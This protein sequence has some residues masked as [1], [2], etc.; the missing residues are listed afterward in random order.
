MELNAKEKQLLQDFVR[1]GY[2]ERYS[3]KLIG[4]GF[5]LFSDEKCKWYE[6]YFELTGTD[7]PEQEVDAYFDVF[8]Y[9]THL[10]SNHFG[11]IENA[12][13]I[14]EILKSKNKLN[15]HI[16]D[17]VISFHIRR[18]GL[19]CDAGMV[20]Y[21]RNEIQ[22]AVF[23]ASEIYGK[24]H[25]KTIKSLAY[26]AKMLD[27]CGCTADAIGFMRDCYDKS[28]DMTYLEN[29]FD[30]SEKLPDFYYDLSIDLLSELLSLCEKNGDRSRFFYFVSRRSVYNYKHKRIE[31]SIDDAKNVKEY[32]YN[33]HIDDEK[34][35]S[36][37]NVS[38]VYY[39][40]DMHEEAEPILRFLFEETYSKMKN[41]EDGEVY[42][43]DDSDFFEI[44]S[45]LFDSMGR[46]GNIKESLDECSKI[47]EMCK[48]S[49]GPYDEKTV[50][51]ACNHARNIY[52]SGK[53]NYAVKILTNLY[54][55]RKI[56][57]EVVR[58]RILEEMSR[59]CA[60]QNRIFDT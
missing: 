49:L 50:I 26:L 16:V 52:R 25:K 41:E 45:M 46:N 58:T 19:L 31:E 35:P 20:T 4:D 54:E 42:F 1:K 5:D 30:M 53:I 57:S 56:F 8:Y 60:L 3:C 44:C 11:A 40:S 13:D 39:W 38:R 24:E 47:Y 29:C 28:M 51:M 2:D 33:E 12:L 17:S 15:E 10:C 59:I 43:D 36:L 21:V 6:R 23:I 32:F 48:S 22:K 27:K 55:K 7:L 37:L 18:S 14:Y 34:L 9:C